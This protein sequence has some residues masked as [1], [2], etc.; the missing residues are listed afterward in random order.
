MYSYWQQ[1]SQSND[2]SDK[3]TSTTQ[4]CGAPAADTIEPSQTVTID[5]KSV[6]DVTVDAGQTVRWYNQL[7]ESVTLSP[8]VR[9][10]SLAC[11]GLAV[12]I[13]PD[14]HWQ[15]T[16]LKTGQWSFKVGSQFMTVTV[17]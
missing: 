3:T 13:E 17:K 16:F 6:G 2:K 8:T 12:T 9:N 10:N 14:G 15:F 7:P 1:K 4:V 11:S 5:G